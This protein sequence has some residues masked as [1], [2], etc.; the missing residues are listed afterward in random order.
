MWQA[1]GD[2]HNSCL[3]LHQV[4]S[5]G[6]GL[7][8]INGLLLTLA[9]TFQI[10]MGPRVGA[11]V[12]AFFALSGVLGCVTATGHAASRHLYAMARAGA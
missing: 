2:S 12:A 1:C 10:F 3:S 6:P 11:V 7:R 8:S 9:P 4:C 5:S